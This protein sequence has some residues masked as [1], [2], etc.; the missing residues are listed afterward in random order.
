MVE[1]APGRRTADWDASTYDLVAAPMTRWGMAVLERLPLQGDETV[2]DAGCGTGQVTHELLER[3]PD[4]N[5]IAL[6]ASPAMLAEARHRLTPFGARVRFVCADLLDLSPD[7]LD[8]AAP[9]D[10]VFST[11]TFH[12]VL[13][14]DRLFANLAAVVRPGG[15][16]V[17][18]CGGEG[19]IAGLLDA[20]R[21]TG[22]ERAGTWLYAGPQETAGRLEAAGFTDVEVW[23]HPEPTAFSDAEE[24]ENYLEAVCLRAHVDGMQAEQRRQFLG[25]VMAAME[26][27]VIDY[28]RLNILARRG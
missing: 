22:G 18:Q 20:V 11:A 24:L 9:V 13:D 1:D 23:T 28:V 25:A 2:V 17:A 7:T 14:H 26:E 16:L 8:V 15:R 19:N 21:V 27:P 5:V 12:W 3:L 4:G 10:A 6:D